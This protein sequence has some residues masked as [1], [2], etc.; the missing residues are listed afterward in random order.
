[1][2]A[3]ELISEIRERT[4]IVSLIGEFVELKQRGANFVGLC[5][6]HSEKSPS[7]NVRRDRQ[8]FHCFGCQESGDA[9]AFLMRLEGLTFPQAA[10]ALAERA[11]IELKEADDREDEARRRERQLTERLC[12]VSE[13]AAVFYVK[14]LEEQAA[15][16]K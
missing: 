6:F 13:A 1:M 7:F 2:I 16:G 9:V 12:S 15:S 14:A 10:R 5:P 3:D 4:D 8:F 11:G